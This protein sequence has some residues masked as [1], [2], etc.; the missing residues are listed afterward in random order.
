MN[1]IQGG[2]G[3]LSVHVWTGLQCLLMLTEQVSSLCSY[4][5]VNFANTGFLLDLGASS[6]IRDQCILIFDLFMEECS[7]MELDM[8]ER[9]TFSTWFYTA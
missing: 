6:M 2:Y 5:S 1:W 7:C 9:D 4:F 8:L 3:I